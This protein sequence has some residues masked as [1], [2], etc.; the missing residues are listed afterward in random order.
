M[1]KLWVVVIL[2]VITVMFTFT[3]AEAGF[4]YHA[5][6]RAAAARIAKNGFTKSFMN[7]N[8]RFGPKAYASS[9]P[10]TALLER[11]GADSMLRFRTSN[12]FNKHLMDTRRMRTA[13]LKNA[14]GLKDMR[15]AMKNE[16]I[17]PMLGQRLGRSAEHS[18][19]IIAYRS[20]KNPHVTNY[21]LPEGVYRNPRMIKPDG[22][23]R[24]N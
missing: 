14:S 11:P 20:A 7:P 9:R 5:T 1:K 2:V 6:K 15:G 4:L 10:S 19:K 3:T 22:I 18:N 21:A 13:D 16:V 8:A 12:N 23:M 24:V 17:C